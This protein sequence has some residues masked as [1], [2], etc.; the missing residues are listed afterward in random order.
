MVDAEADQVIIANV[1][2][3]Y[4]KIHDSSDINC[5]LPGDKLG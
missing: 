3:L 4:D 2:N 1:I 5:N